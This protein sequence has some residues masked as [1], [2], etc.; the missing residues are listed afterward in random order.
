MHL[1]PQ[2]RSCCKNL[3]PLYVGEINMDSLLFATDFKKEKVLYSTIFFIVTPLLHNHIIQSDDYFLFGRSY[4]RSDSICL[5]KLEA[6]I[7]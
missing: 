2:F 7:Q 3:G 4:F 1:T 6:T 5:S